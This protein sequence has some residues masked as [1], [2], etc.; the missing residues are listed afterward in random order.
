[1]PL[2]KNSDTLLNVEGLTTY[3]DISGGLLGNNR[4]G[5]QLTPKSD[6]RGSSPV[7]NLT[8]RALS[9]MTVS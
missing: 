6:Q 2:D 9:T 7:E 5:L 4:D 1:M 8:R 3:F